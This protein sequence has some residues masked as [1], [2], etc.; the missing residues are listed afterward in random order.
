MIAFG[1]GEGDEVITVANTFIATV[2]AIAMT[3]AKPVVVDVLEDTGLMDPSKLE[4]AITDKT[5]VIIPVHLFGQCCDMDPINEIAASTVSRSSRMPARPMARS[6]RAAAPVPWAMRQL[7]RSIRARTSD[8]SVREGRSRLQTRSVVATVKGLRHHGQIVKNEH[9][10]L[11]YNYRLHAMQA[12]VLGVKL[13]HLDGWNEK[14]RQLAARYQSNLEGAGYLDG[15]DRGWLRACISSFPDWLQRQGS[16]RKG[17]ER[18]RDRL[19]TALPDTGPSSARL[20]VSGIFGRRFSRRGETHENKPYTS[21]VPGTETGTGR[22]G[23]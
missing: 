8:H 4:G 5:K 15:R 14:R 6:T 23:L 1:V 18:S 7:S 2:E 16:S 21:D 12:A 13:N 3:G 17:A 9:S 20:P 11:G 19:G 22:R 10:V